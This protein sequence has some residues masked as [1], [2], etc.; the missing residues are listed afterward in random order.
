MPEPPPEPV[1]VVLESLHNLINLNQIH[2]YEGITKVPF[3]FFDVPDRPSG[4]FA[5]FA[6]SSRHWLAAY[7]YDLTRKPLS[8]PVLRQICN[9]LA[10]RALATRLGTAPDEALTR[11]LD[12]EPVLA[13][14]V[15]FMQ[16][17]GLEYTA[18]MEAFQKELQKFAGEHGLLKRYGKR[19]PGAAN[20]LSRQL[21]LLQPALARL[22]INVKIVR[23][24]GS[25]ITLSRRADDPDGPSSEASSGHKTNPI[26]DIG[27]ESDGDGL[28][29]QLE[30]RRRRTAK[31]H[32]GDDNGNEG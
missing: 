31:E 25:Y 7:A 27:P 32:E 21:R 22:G 6:P 23:R 12:S 19:F 26:N 8:E 1:L 14:V 4:H 16:S 2:L 28:L 3:V 10:G 11:M 24:D 29:A 5:L 13:A 9:V 20:T 15:E 18:R 30:K 17:K